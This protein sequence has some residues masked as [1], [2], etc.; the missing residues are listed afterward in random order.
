MNLNSKQHLNVKYVLAW[1]W[2]QIP[3]SIWIQ[4]LS[5]PG[6]EFEVQAD[7]EF[8]LCLVMNSDKISGKIWI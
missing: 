5:V 7:Y 6:Y 3:R 2:I 4:I 1:L 8:C